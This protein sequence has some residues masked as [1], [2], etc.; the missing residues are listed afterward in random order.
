MRGKTANFETL[1]SSKI[2]DTG[3]RDR[4]IRETRSAAEA[5]EKS[6]REAEGVADK[7]KQS[8]KLSLAVSAFNVSMKNLDVRLA[9]EVRLQTSGKIAP[10]RPFSAADDDFHL[11][12]ADAA[13][14]LSESGI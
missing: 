7:R 10:R 12:S 11:R 2:F 4:L 3:T 1:V 8:D 6:V 5:F 9:R 13:R 14:F